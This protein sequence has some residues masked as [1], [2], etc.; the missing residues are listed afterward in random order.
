[1]SRWL[2]L[3]A[4]AF[5]SLVSAS[6]AGAAP[7][8]CP[9]LAFTP[10][11]E[12]LIYGIQADGV[13][14]DEATAFFGSARAGSEESWYCDVVEGRTDGGLRCVRK[15]G[16]RLAATFGNGCC[17]FSVTPTVQ[18]H[19][20]GS[21]SL[22][23]V[24]DRACASFVVGRANSTAYDEMRL[25]ASGA[26]RKAP[27]ARLR[28]LSRAFQGGKVRI[29]RGSTAMAPKWGRS[30]VVKHR[31][32]RWRCRYQGIGQSGPTY[33]VS[34]TRGATGSAGMRWRTG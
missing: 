27:C 6:T 34:C 26:V 23:D 20:E 17:D 15:D 7:Q 30:F 28:S 19:Q 12:E 18:P 31:A 21:V 11:T 29:P 8:Q 1:M 24:G 22:P 2:V 32:E 9:S 25:P 3:L 13:D 14:C 5:G 33:Q 16:A 10:M 4:V